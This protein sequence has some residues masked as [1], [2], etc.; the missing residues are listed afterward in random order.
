MVMPQ[1]QRQ[2]RAIDTWWRT[3]RPEAPDQFTDDFARVVDSLEQHP[4]RGIR[5]SA[6]DPNRRILV[7]ARTKTLVMYRIRPRAR[8]V[9]IVEVRRP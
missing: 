5:S 3:N 1:A 6:K 4:S 8:R 7:T 2:A 9:E